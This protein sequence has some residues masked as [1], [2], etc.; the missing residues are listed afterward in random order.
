MRTIDVHTHAYTR[1]YLE[2][3]RAKGGVYSLRV[4]PD[5]REEIFRGETPVALPQPGHLDYDLRIEAMDQ[6][7]IDVSIVSLTLRSRLRAC[8]VWPW[9]EPARN[10]YVQT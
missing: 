9:A 8:G 1:E 2:T 3:L 5:G 6:N 4:R 10:P 7:H